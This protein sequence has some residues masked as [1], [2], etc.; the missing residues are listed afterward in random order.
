MGPE[1]ACVTMNTAD[2][3]NRTG[4]VFNIQRYSI[5][6]GPGIRTL[7]FIKGCPLS[8]EWCSN[9][10]SQELE[11]QLVVK[12]E[13]CIGCG[14]CIPACP[15]SDGVIPDP[16]KVGCLLCGKC[17]EICP[18]NARE[19]IGSKMTIDQIIHEV[20]KD[21]KYYEQ[22]GGGVTISGGEPLIQANF[23][24]DLIKSLKS[25]HINS[26]I[27]TTGFGNEDKLLKIAAE[28]SHVLFD[29]KHMDSGEH[30]KH[31]GVGNE[32][33]LGNAE[34]LCQMFPEKIIFRMPL[35]GGVNSDNRN[36]T[37]TAQFVKKNGITI[38]HLLPYHEYGS[39][40]YKKLDKKYKCEAYTPDAE[41]ISEIQKIFGS[42]GIDT[43][44]GG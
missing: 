27:E 36:I 19:I 5:H 25:L 6:D 34:K 11:R 22:S 9:P 37:A 38:I 32:L 39:G 23:V 13:L 33:I 15:V 28:C 29:L 30:K 2:M 21:R 7:V 24:L 16:R 14:R 43:E 35:I 40:K 26:A 44:I 20:E 41:E 8:C 1:A 18:A 31:T 12:P 4:T 42:F 17:A 3:V 10:E